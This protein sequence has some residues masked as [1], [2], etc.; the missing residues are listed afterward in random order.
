MGVK[1]VPYSLFLIRKGI[2]NEKNVS[3]LI[4]C[5]IR[6]KKWHELFI[7]YSLFYSNS[8]NVDSLNA[9]SPNVDSP[10]AFS[11]NADSP[12]VDLANA[13]SLNTESPNANSLNAD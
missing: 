5:L 8:P 9:E 12:N 7:P 4:S 13:D 6:N 2:T 11:P 10:N 1:L 3:F